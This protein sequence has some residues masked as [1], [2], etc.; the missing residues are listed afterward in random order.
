MHRYAEGG[1]VSVPGD[2]PKYGFGGLAKMNI[3]GGTAPLANGG[4]MDRLRANRAQF[5]SEGTNAFLEENPMATAPAVPG[6]SMNSGSAP[7]RGAG[8]PQA[9]IPIASQTPGMAPPQMIGAGMQMPRAAEG[10][11]MEVGAVPGAQPPGPQPQPQQSP[12]TWKPKEDYRARLAA[13]QHESENMWMMAGGLEGVQ[14]FRNMSDAAARREIMGYGLQAIR[15]MD[16]GMVGE[17]M[18]AGNSALEATPFDTGMKFIARN[19]ELHMQGKDG[20]PSGP[21]NSDALRAFVEDHMKTPEAYL[22]WKKQNETGRHNLETEATARVTAQSGRM[23]AEAAREKASYAGQNADASTLTAL[24]AYENSQAA[25]ERAQRMALEAAAGG[26][27]NNNRMAI[28]RDSDDWVL[29]NF[30]PLHEDIGNH[31]KDNPIAWVDFKNDVLELQL[32]NP[33]NEDSQSGSVGR[34]AASVVSQL[35][36]QPGGVSEGDLGLEEGDFQISEHAE[37][38]GELIAN[39]KG[40]LIA[41]PKVMHADARKNSAYREGPAKDP[42]V[43]PDPVPAGVLPGAQAAP[44]TPAGPVDPDAPPLAKEDEEAGYRWGQLGNGQWVLMNQYGDPETSLAPP[45][46]REQPFKGKT[47][48]YIMGQRPG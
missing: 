46:K 29:D 1:A 18:R 27:D 26:W 22:D 23:T 28:E 25:R 44:P 35:V 33:W 8:V 12:T 34:D 3:G 32:Y 47:D 30:D 10:G 43:N 41:L 37:A 19:G 21:L 6:G 17:A 45:P 5:R 11:P 16:E 40:Q 13:W 2:L 42:N 39:Y 48:Q 20:V 14:K 9:A 31:F 36:R 15:N 7:L 38:P 24:A 4:W